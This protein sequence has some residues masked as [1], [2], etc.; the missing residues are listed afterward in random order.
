MGRRYETLDWRTGAVD[1]G[2][3]RRTWGLR[4][5]TPLIAASLVA[6]AEISFLFPSAESDGKPP[7]TFEPVIDAPAFVRPAKPSPD[8]L[9]GPRIRVG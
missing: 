8:V 4:I 1:G 5:T 3:S 2:D 9:I 6:L 7:A